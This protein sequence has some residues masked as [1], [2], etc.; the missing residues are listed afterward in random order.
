MAKKYDASDDLGIGAIIRRMRESKGW[1]VN[2]LSK[3]SGVTRTFIHDIEAGRYS[4]RLT[5]L[6]KL[7]K[8]FEIELGD[9]LKDISA[10]VGLSEDETRLIEA[11]RRGEFGALLQVVS[12]RMEV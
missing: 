1:N 5:T 4:P 2:Q 11:Y 9:L 10:P 8:A 7:A 12:E 6:N 3:K